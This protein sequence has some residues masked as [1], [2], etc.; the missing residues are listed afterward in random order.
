MEK[1]LVGIDRIN[2]KRHGNQIYYQIAYLQKGLFR[3]F[4]MVELPFKTNTM[5]TNY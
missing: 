3:F 2:K 4:E 1:M 5:A